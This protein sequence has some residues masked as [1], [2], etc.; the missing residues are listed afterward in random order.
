MS[1][2]RK[3]DSSIGAV[4]VSTEVT[5]VHMSGKASR[6]K[7]ES[8]L[9]HLLRYP[10]GKGR[11]LNALK[12]FLPSGKNIRGRYIDPFIGGASVFFYLQPK[13]A[14]LSDSNP[15]LID[16]YSALQ[17]CPYDIWELYRQIPEGKESYYNTRSIDPSELERPMRAAR[18]LYLNRTCFKGMWRH[19]SKG[20]FNIG[21]GGES[22]RW[23]LSNPELIE[24]SRRLRSADLRCS[25]FEPIVREA[26]K[27]DFLFID[28]PYRP[29]YREMQNA[30]YMGQQF[31]YSD[32]VRLAAALTQ[33]TTRGVPW[34]MTN[35]SHP[36]IL[37]LYE[38]DYTATMRVGTGAR[39][40]LLSVGGDE[41]VIFNEPA[42]HLDLAVPFCVSTL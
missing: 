27:A 25:D 14:L 32:Q 28:P 9:P 29:G 21:Y 8:L 16:L 26:K 17:E 15:D 5:A 19:N 41:A 7:G 31:I 1:S 22:R 34:V 10:G 39:P 24:A 2:Q 42:A 40:G 20:Q 30:H 13:N 33:A 12:F 4:A 11:L 3:V 18:L 37:R 38:G 23:V 36:D 6:Q 35:S